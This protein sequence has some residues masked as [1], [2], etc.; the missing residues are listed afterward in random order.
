MLLQLGL[1]QALNDS[2]VQTR[3]RRGGQVLGHDTLGDAQSLGAM[4]LGMTQA[5]CMMKDGFDYAH[6]Q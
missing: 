1:A 5:K 2:P 4:A 6:T 3:R